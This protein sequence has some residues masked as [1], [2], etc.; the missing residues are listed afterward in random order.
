MTSTKL[1]SSCLSKAADDEPIFV[2]RAQDRLAPKIVRAWAAT[3]R[4]HGISDDKY[5]KAMQTAFEMEQ[6]PNRKFPT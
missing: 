2:L 5:K 1:N 3:A 4:L 6:W